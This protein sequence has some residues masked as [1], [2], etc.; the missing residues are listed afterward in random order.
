MPK[1]AKKHAENT[2][3]KITII[4]LTFAVSSSL[5]SFLCSTCI[6]PLYPPVK[7]FV[8]SPVAMNGFSFSFRTSRRNLAYGASKSACESNVVIQYTF[9]AYDSGKM[10]YANW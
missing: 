3:S 1:C 8:S 9:F 2:S 4:F 7:S 5:E 6:G 10:R